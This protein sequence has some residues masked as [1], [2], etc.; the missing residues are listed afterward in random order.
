MAAG[1]EAAQAFAAALETIVHLGN[2]TFGPAVRRK[3]TR[4]LAGRETTT[5]ACAC[6]ATFGAT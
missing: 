1:R 2:G 6:G 4:T 5:T 3:T